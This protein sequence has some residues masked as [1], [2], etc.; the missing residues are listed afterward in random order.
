MKHIL[1]VDDDALMLSVIQRALPQFRVTL[2]Q[3]GETALALAS[4]IGNIDLLITD[5]LMP[6]MTGDEL[7]GR[8]R[9]TRPGLK[10]LLVTGH[11]EIL[12]RELA[13]WWETEAHL[14]KPFRIDELREAVNRLIG[15]P[16][17]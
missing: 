6:S 7:L 15:P 9:E 5:Y 17:P 3:D 4:Q 12:S 13:G 14:S 1:V 8:L 10:A 11:G 2:A 16:V